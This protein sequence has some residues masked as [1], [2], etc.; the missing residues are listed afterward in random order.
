M[1]YGCVSQ[2]CIVIWRPE[3]FA[4]KEFRFKLELKDFDWTIPCSSFHQ[5]RGQRKAEPGGSSVGALFSVAV[6][7]LFLTQVGFFSPFTL[8][9]CV[10]SWICQP[11]WIWNSLSYR[12][13]HAQLPHGDTHSKYDSDK[14]TILSK[15]NKH[16]TATLLLLEPY[17]W[18]KIC[19]PV[20]GARTMVNAQKILKSI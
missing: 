1:K 10:C 6:S 18:V 16:L 14:W 3:T 15:H 12:D 9:V 4:N 8:C 11:F 17:Q 2:W 20:G 5:Q 19:C 13:M 7:L